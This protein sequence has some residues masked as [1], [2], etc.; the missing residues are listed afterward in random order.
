MI[1]DVYTL[2]ECTYE[3]RSILS[4]ESR[5]TPHKNFKLMSESNSTGLRVYDPDMNEPPIDLTSIKPNVT[6]PKVTLLL[7]R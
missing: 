7:R 2:P 6:A 4:R 5:L 1:Y 3:P